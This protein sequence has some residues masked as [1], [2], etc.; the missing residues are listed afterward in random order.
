MA[1]LFCAFVV[2]AQDDPTIMTINGRPV[3]RSEFEYSYNK[4][5]TDNVVDKKTVAQ[6]VELFVNYKLKVEAALAARLDTTQAFRNEF[7]D[8]RDQ[9]VRPSFVNN[10]D[11]EKAA[12]QLYD[13]TRQRI[14]GQGGLIRVAHI[15][16]LLPQKAAKEKQRSAE[17]RIDSI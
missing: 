11:V 13:D 14:E 7:A 1:L 17:Q 4:N 10:D 5:N 16:L 12:R 8:Y 6:Y 2:H 3:S 9:Q 15:M